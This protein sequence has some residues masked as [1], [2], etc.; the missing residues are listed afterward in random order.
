MDCV[1]GSYPDSGNNQQGSI[2]LLQ[3]F[4]SKFWINQICPVTKLG[5]I[6]VHESSVGRGT[7]Q[8][9]NEKMKNEKCEWRHHCAWKR[10]V[11][12]KHWAFHPPTWRS[13]PCWT[14]SLW[15]PC[16]RTGHILL[17]LFQMEGTKNNKKNNN[18]FK[19]KCFS[20]TQRQLPH[21]Q[22][23]AATK[24]ATRWTTNQTTESRVFA[25]QR[26]GLGVSWMKAG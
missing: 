5:L 13:A 11:N 3:L 6:Q 25:P 14:I 8:P 18:T 20:K 7:V 12:L 15:L 10:Q 17:C 2:I 16:V 23:F 4:I 26:G 9:K 22:M 19:S 21:I 1:C 24:C